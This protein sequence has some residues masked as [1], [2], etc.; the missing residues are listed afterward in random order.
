M[1]GGGLIAALTEVDAVILRAGGGYAARLECV[2]LGS[3]TS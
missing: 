1:K 3:I 2:N